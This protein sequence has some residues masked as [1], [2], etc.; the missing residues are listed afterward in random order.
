MDEMS[1]VDRYGVAVFTRWWPVDSPRGVVLI[2]H[3]ASE[4]SGRY[5]RF[6][7]ALNDVGFAAVALDHRGHGVTGAS[8][9]AGLMGP[10][11]GQSVIDDLDE[12]RVLAATRFGSEV[13]A[14]VFGHSMGSLIAFGYLCHHSDGL[15]GG[16]LCG[17][18]ANV[19]ESAALAGL[20]QGFADT[21]M[22]DEPAADLL[23][24]D[25]TMFEPVRTPYDWLSRDTDEVDRY[26]ADPYCGDANP[27][28]YGYLIDLLETIAPAADHLASIACPVLVIAG[29]HDPAGAM[30]AHPTAL[31][32]RLRAAGVETQLTMYEGA[33]HEI[34]N[35]TNRE[36][37]TAD[38]IG[39][40]DSTLSSSAVG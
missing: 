1:F 12:L 27:L 4:H 28:T 10:G 24:N 31:E 20:L 2:A 40:L 38:I 18:P 5:D 14:Y 37:V 30:G 33:R 36:K 21:G 16:I 11:G 29:D 22:R 3:G 32:N 39:W 17:V 34:L 25:Q 6:A 23:R 19:D 13:P 7:R 15:A 26:L 8:T 35:E 9:G